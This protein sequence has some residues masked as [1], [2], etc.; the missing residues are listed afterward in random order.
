MLGKAAEAFGGSAKWLR[1][2]AEETGKEPGMQVKPGGWGEAASSVVPGL[3]A[4]GVG[5]VNPL[6]GAAA[7][8]GLFGGSAYTTTKEKLEEQGLEPGAAPLLTGAV[9]G[10][11]Q[12]G[13]TVLGAKLFTGALGRI[14]GSAQGAL[15]AWVSPSTVGT[16]AKGLAIDQAVQLPTQAA[17]A[18]A[19]TGIERAYGAQNEPTP[20]DA[21]KDSVG[22][23]LKM[24]TLMAPFAAFG[25]IKSNRARAQTA[26]VVAQPPPDVA[27]LSDAQKASAVDKR[28]AGLRQIYEDIQGR[29]PRQV[30]AWRLEAMQAIANHDPVEMNLDWKYERPAKPSTALTTGMPPP[31]EGEYIPAG[32]GG[33]EGPPPTGTGM[34]G[35][36]QRRG[37]GGADWAYGAEGGEEPPPGGG[38]GGFPRLPGPPG[39]AGLLP[40]RNEQ[41]EQAFTAARARAAE[42]SVQR[43]A[44]LSAQRQTEWDAAM[45]Q[46][47]KQ[48]QATVLKGELPTA[49]RGRTGVLGRLTGKDGEDLAAEVRK[50]WAEKIDSKS[51]PKYLAELEAFHEKLTGRKLEDVIAEERA[52]DE[53]ARSTTEKVGT[54]AEPEPAAA[55]AGAEA[56]RVGEQ[57]HEGAGHG[58]A[59]P[60][61]AVEGQAA[62]PVAGADDLSHVTS[63]EPHAIEA[64]S[65]LDAVDQGG[66]PAFIS[67]KLRGVAEGFG[68]E[69]KRDTTPDALITR[70]REALVRADAAAQDRARAYLTRE[71]RPELQ[72]GEAVPHG[73][74]TARPTDKEIP[75][76]PEAGK[77]PEGG[78]PEHTG[79]EGQRE[80]PPPQAGDSNRAGERSPDGT[81]YAQPRNVEEAEGNVARAK[82]A[83]DAKQGELNATRKELSQLNAQI[84]ANPL[85]PDTQRR[86]ITPEQQSR[87]DELRGRVETLVSERD[88]WNEFKL[89]S[90]AVGKAEKERAKAEPATRG[91]AEPAETIDFWR[92]KARTDRSIDSQADIL[93]AWLT[94]LKNLGKITSEQKEILKDL[95]ESVSSYY[96]PTQVSLEAQHLAHDA[97][98]REGK[99]KLLNNMAQRWHDAYKFAEEKSVF[100]NKANAAERRAEQRAAERALEEVEAESVRKADEEEYVRNVEYQ[101]KVNQIAAAL[102][103]G[104]MSQ[105]DADYRLKLAAKGSDPELQAARQLRRQRAQQAEQAAQRMIDMLYAK[106]RGIEGLSDPA[107]RARVQANS[108][109]QAHMADIARRHRNPVIRAVAR[110]LADAKLTATIVEVENPDF[111]GGRYVPATD[112]IEIGHGGMNTL[113]LMHESVHALTHKLMAEAMENIKRPFEDLTKQQQAGV[114]ALR[115]V[116]ALMDRFSKVADFDDPAHRIAMNDEHEFVS[117]AL[118]NPSIQYALDSRGWLSKLFHKIANAM[119]FD[120]KM[121]AEMDQLMRA[122]SA[123]FGDPNAASKEVYNRDYDIGGISK[124]FNHLASVGPKAI[125]RDALYGNNVPH[126]VLKQVLTWLTHNQVFHM[127]QK[128]TERI[129]RDFPAVKPIAEAF[130]NAY[131]R[132]RDVK[133]TMDSAS[134]YLSQEGSNINQRNIRLQESNPK[135]FEKLTNMANEGTRLELDPSAKTFAEAKKR[136]PD[137]TPQQWGSREA[138]MLRAD[139]AAL[140]RESAQMLRADPKADTPI[141]MYNDMQVKH[142]LDFSRQ[143]VNS[144]RTALSA[145]DLTHHPV[146]KA[147]YTGKDVNGKEYNRLDMLAEP[148]RKLG[149][150]DQLRE[151]NKGVYDVEQAITKELASKLGVAEKDVNAAYEL[152]VKNKAVPKDMVDLVAARDTISDIRGHYA[153][154]QKVPYFHLGRTGDYVVKFTVG[155]GQAEWDR[156]GAIVGADPIFGG[157]GGLGRG[158]GPPKGGTNR[159]VYMRFDSDL[160]HK[161]AEEMLLPLEK[162]GL[163]KHPTTGE[164]TWASGKVTE[165]LREQTQ[166]TPQFV[167][168]ME[169]R[170]KQKVEDGVYDEATGRSMINDMKDAY[171]ASLPESSPLKARMFRDGDVGYSRDFVN[172]FGDRLTMSKGAIVNSYGAPM[173]AEV[174]KDLHAARQ[175][176]DRTPGLGEYAKKMGIY[177]DEL[178]GRAND[179]A[180]PVQ[181]PMWDRIRALP[182]SW[183]LM[184]V[185]A[186]MAT[187]G[188][189]PFQMMVPI[190]GKRYGFVDTTMAMARSYGKATAALNALLKMGWADPNN[191]G[192]SKYDKLANLSELQ[193]VFGKILDKK[194]GM[195]MFTGHDLNAL[196]ALQWSSQLNFG[197]VNQIARLNPGEKGVFGAFRKAINVATIMPHYIEVLNRIVSTLTAHEMAITKGGLSPEAAQKYAMQVVRDV[198]GDHS[199]ANIARKLGRRGVAGPF[200]PSMV[201]FEQF[202]IQQTETTMREII[203]LFSP[204][205]QAKERKEAAKAL[206]GLTTTTS[207]IAGTL[208]LPLVSLF[209][210]V[211]NQVLSWSQDS[212]D[213]PPDVQASWRNTMAGIFG[214]KGGEIVS[215][216]APRALDFDMSSRAGLADIAP[217]SDF[218]ASRR[219]IEDKLAEGGLNLLG[220]AFGVGAGLWTGTHAL[221]DHNYPLAINDMLPTFARNIAKAYRMSQYGYEST[222]PGNQPLPLEPTAWNI[223]MQAAGFT[224]GERAN[225]AERAYAYHTNQEL[226]Q[227]RQSVIRNDMYRAIDHQDYGDLGRLFQENVAFQIKHPSMAGIDLTS[228]VKQRAMTRATADFS[229]TGILAP[230]RAYP[231][232]QN[233]QFSG[234]Q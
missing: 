139:W 75:N 221:L 165:S 90:D 99:D 131:G 67:Q 186:Y 125:Y 35:P 104:K 216:G 87:R 189:Q 12:A 66:V 10:V 105:K 77:Q 187:I 14:G 148:Y 224:G 164:S 179:M 157:R 48:E 108:S 30:A 124:W 98:V 116:R 196:E 112:R 132:F 195:P 222:A 126:A 153:Y 171:L 160:M 70:V 40:Y 178:R 182:A 103:A 204:H 43:Q 58:A 68:I 65:I 38:G 74:F 9:Q 50:I 62:A 231:Q 180:K 6:A 111:K 156:V 101:Q 59:E 201:G 183:R 11:G 44:A 227:H 46:R 213:D 154:H 163:F 173:M 210:A 199:Q 79:T 114:S 69:V 208:G 94:S 63:R 39:P 55:A 121:S 144:I 37:G 24:T 218:L 202:G 140:E 18:A 57:V 162:A 60:T 230:P 109:A 102:E 117:E 234:R 135:L 91:G 166:A 82:A 211:A 113:T 233:F 3:G 45:A 138:Q 73:E 200:T 86:Q 76:A 8:A 52:K 190:V 149:I 169:G 93:H 92:K 71:G 155:G 4:V 143:M 217:F 33:P 64:R 159:D 84:Y 194:T 212:N 1:R 13:L 198:D 158:W 29:D 51:P 123:F 17:A 229:G 78:V 228:G 23:T 188:L 174:L 41:M 27:N 192:L 5:L 83:L 100:T 88:Q 19:V 181:S 146:V 226:L 129:G 147:A 96:R 137:L 122:S 185:P 220:P 128:H 49:T 36:Y 120:T 141:K 61:G 191:A 118:N 168:T 152:L 151:L 145:F 25:I 72:P 107:L 34:V 95:H 225:I 134:S 106:K 219:K 161:R 56:P 16:L 42:E 127:V 31:L 176:L 85:H 22:P 209:T 177:A 89:H 136:N 7:A 97:I 214:E 115:E 133:A 184:M 47:T 119:G 193:F 207:I 203:N 197:Q 2:Y 54:G 81:W 223:G 205:T 15:D 172:T 150:H 142:S 28:E 110:M 215:R 32:Q 130:A 167:R 232:L 206:A 170:I 175:G 20:W 53:A 26:E 21:A 80:G